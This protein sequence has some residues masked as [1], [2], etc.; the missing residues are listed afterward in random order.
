MTFAAE[1][2]WPLGDQVEGDKT[3]GQGMFRR[4]E[5]TGVE[6]SKAE[7]TGVAGSGQGVPHREE[8]TRVEL[9]NP[10]ADREAGAISTDAS[11]VTGAT[12]ERQPTVVSIEGGRSGGGHGGAG[13][14]FGL[15][16]PGGSG[17]R[18]HAL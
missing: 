15:D 17:H 3:Q 6:S 4:E 13:L 16:M 5:M 14:D 8:M 7:V 18:S 2:G 1:A 11:S 9:A 12:G 10:L